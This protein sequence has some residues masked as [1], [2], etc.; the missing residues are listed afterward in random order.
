MREVR[1]DIFKL[2][3]FIRD[4][5]VIPTSIG[6][7]KDGSNPMGK[8]LARE[9]ARRFPILPITYGEFCMLQGEHT[10]VQMDR[11]TGPAGGR[12]LVLFPTKALNKAMPHMSW[13]GKASPPLIERGLRQLSVFEPPTPN[14]KI[15]VP[16]LGCGWGGLHRD[17]VRELMDRYLTAE[18]FVRVRWAH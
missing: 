2:A 18:C 16:L 1:G 14:G 4:A 17:A 6:W 10:P 3:N 11:Y 5:V 7:K 13:Q 9:A 12:W 8:G 15:Y